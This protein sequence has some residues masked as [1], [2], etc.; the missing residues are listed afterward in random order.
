MFMLKSLESINLCSVLL[1]LLLAFALY[2]IN[3][4]LGEVQYKY[5]DSLFT[6]SKF[7]FDFEKEGNFS[8]NFFL[9]V[10]NPSIYLAICSALLQDAVSE[11]TFSVLWLI[12]SFYWLLRFL[13]IFA[14]NRRHIINWKYEIASLIL[15]HIFSFTTFQSIITPLYDSKESIFISLPALRDAVWYAILAYLVV[16][17]WNIC[18][19]TFNSSR[20]YSEEK[21]HEIVIRRYKKLKE[22]YDSL[23]SI[24]FSSHSFT[25][26]SD[27]T[28]LKCLVYSIMIYEDYNR[29]PVVRV[30]ESFIKRIFPHRKMSLGIMQFQT[31]TY[32]NDEQSIR[33]AI[34][35]LYSSYMQCSNDQLQCAI[36]DYNPSPDYSEEVNAIYDELLK[37][38]FTLS[39]D[40]YVSPRI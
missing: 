19:S 8:G 32:I 29:P 37:S 12:V 1:T 16:M 6:Y 7:S 27:E 38:E 23:V 40:D 14:F 22:K 20:V 15:S 25:Y 11:Q 31:T 5:R 36:R 35:K 13:Y 21:H 34:D 33:L 18:K 10:V 39:Y 4:L 26:S 2:I 28:K 17:I 24:C 30:I 9:K 3:F